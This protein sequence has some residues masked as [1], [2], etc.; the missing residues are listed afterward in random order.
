MRTLGVS[1][2]QIARWVRTGILLRVLPGVYAVGH[3]AASFEAD[4]TAAVLYAGPGA[5]LSHATATWW[6]ELSER[7]PRIIDVTTPRR[8][9]SLDGI[10][11]HDRRAR[12]R[13]W[14]RGL[15]TT[16]P[17][18]TLLD[19]ATT[20]DFDDLRYLLAQADY[21]R[22]VD[23]AEV[24]AALTTGRPGS[25]M[26]RRALIHHMPQLARTR[27]PLEIGFL[28]RV[29]E[30]HNIPLP[31]VNARLHGFT[32]DA[33][34]RRQRVVV[35]LD[36]GDGHTTRAQMDRDRRR[37]LA[38]RMHGFIVIRYTGNQVYFEP[39]AVAADLSRTLAERDTPDK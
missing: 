4:L 19:V 2:T 26:L 33:L 36:G 31:E 18:D 27:S 10:R 15:P 13:V 25:P 5:G 23:L 3:V 34:W 35:E 1:S 6:L 7:R 20:T 14:V 16:G 21:R 32:V 29:C 9:K 17:I 8:C 28:L 22:L 11:V 37:D 24:P 39:E 12:D 38:L 30:G